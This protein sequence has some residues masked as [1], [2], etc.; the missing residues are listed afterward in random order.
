MEH[1]TNK[2][3]TVGNPKP[4]GQRGAHVADTVGQAYKS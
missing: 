3:S 1:Q 4:Q 2:D